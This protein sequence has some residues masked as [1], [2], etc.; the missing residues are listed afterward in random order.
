MVFCCEG[1]IVFCIAFGIIIGK[2]GEKARIMIDFFST[3]N[4]IVMRLVGLVMWQVHQYSWDDP[5]GA[6]DLI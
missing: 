2:M 1:I 6:G 5:R 3:L 4:E